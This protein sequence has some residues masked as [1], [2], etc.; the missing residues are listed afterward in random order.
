MYLESPTKFEDSRAWIR[1]AFDEFTSNT[2]VTR[3][4]VSP[5]VYVTFFHARTGGAPFSAFSSNIY[6]VFID[7]LCKVLLEQRKIMATIDQLVKATN[8]LICSSKLCPSA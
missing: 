8:V 5:S 4:F 6:S 7:K 1:V 3:R 2:M